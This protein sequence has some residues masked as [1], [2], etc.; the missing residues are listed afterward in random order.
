M[1][2]DHDDPL[3]LHQT[4]C[5][6]S[7]IRK[8]CEDL[9]LTPI[10]YFSAKEKVLADPEVLFMTLHDMR[11]LTTLDLYHCQCLMDVFLQQKWISVRD[12][13]YFK[14]WE[15][16]ERYEAEQGTWGED[17]EEGGLMHGI[18]G[19]IFA[20]LEG[21]VVDKGD[22]VRWYLLGMG[23]MARWTVNP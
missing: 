11:L 4:D 1:H 16:H 13:V 22:K 20:N 5:C 9:H 18:N 14:Y 23:M 3:K 8:L 7:P 2:G 21:Y 10:Q 12:L 19:Y 6:L 17:G 15:D